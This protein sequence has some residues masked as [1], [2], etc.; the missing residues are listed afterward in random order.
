MVAGTGKEKNIIFISFRSTFCVAELSLGS[1]NQYNSLVL[2]HLQHAPGSIVHAAMSTT[3]SSPVWQDW[4]VGHFIM[5]RQLILIGLH[6]KLITPGDLKAA[7]VSD[8][9]KGDRS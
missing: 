9:T 4:L 5:E 6:L 3:R 2:S 1:I 7:R 8:R